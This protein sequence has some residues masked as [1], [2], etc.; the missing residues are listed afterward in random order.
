MTTT[1]IVLDS[2]NT[3]VVESGGPLEAIVTEAN[4]TVV[5]QSESTYAI[6]AGTLGP[7]SIATMDD[8]DLRNLSDGSLLIYSTQASK[9]TA[10]NLL[11]KQIIE[12]G[13]Y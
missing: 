4:N 12:S 8:V 6:V 2:V 3:L 11:E 13:Q 1:T 7:N 9:W 10:S 5:V